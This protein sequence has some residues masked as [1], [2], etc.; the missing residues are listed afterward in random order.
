MVVMVMVLL[1]GG[2]RDAARYG[3]TG[4]TPASGTRE[5]E[6]VNIIRNHS[7][8]LVDVT[9]DDVEVLIYDDF[10]SVDS[11]DELVTDHNGNG[12]WD[13]ADGD[14]YNDLNG[15]GAWDPD[16]GVPGAGD[17]SAIVL[18]RVTASWKALTPL[19]AP[20]I[21]NGGEIPVSASVVIRNEPFGFSGGP[22][23][24]GSGT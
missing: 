5:Q 14:T 11:G 7:L 24:G 16:P 8:G 9:T 6:I 4:Q 20:F 2:V 22:L 23:S 13:E 17:G 21:G 12:D 19:V 10:D 1:E 15:N 18:Y 3:M